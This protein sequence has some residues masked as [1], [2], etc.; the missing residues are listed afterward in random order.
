METDGNTK[1]ER[2]ASTESLKADLKEKLMGLIHHP[3][4]PSEDKDKL[5][6]IVDKLVK[7]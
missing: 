5:L 6:M 1:R 7:Q 4:T 3:G 2:S